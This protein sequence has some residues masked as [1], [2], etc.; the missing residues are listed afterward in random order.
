MFTPFPAPVPPIPKKFT[1]DCLR[2]K[3]FERRYPLC[4]LFQRETRL[5]SVPN[6]AVKPPGWYTWPICIY[7]YDGQHDNKREKRPQEV[8]YGKYHE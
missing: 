3:K 7:R 8:Q 6:R 2:V 1:Y 4:P 5:P